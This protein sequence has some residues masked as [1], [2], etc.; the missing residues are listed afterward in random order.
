MPQ[1]VL[2]HTTHLLEGRGPARLFFGVDVRPLNNLLP[3]LLIVVAICEE[4][5]TTSAT[6]VRL[7]RR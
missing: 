7:N 6:L 3:A 1:D 4:E 5:P 2:G